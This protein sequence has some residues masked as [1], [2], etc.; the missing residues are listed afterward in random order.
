MAGRPKGGAI[1][2]LLRFP[3]ALLLGVALALPVAAQEACG[4]MIT[5]APGDS[6]SAIARRC[7]TTLVDLLQANP[8][9]ASPNLI[10][11]GQQLV[12]AIVEP[13]TFTSVRVPLIEIGAGDHHSER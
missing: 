10:V 13:A 11:V 1:R 2:Y 4:E 8:G 6:L 3:L 12:I 9:I 5:V 7:D